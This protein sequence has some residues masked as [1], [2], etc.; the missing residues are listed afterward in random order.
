MMCMQVVDEDLCR[1]S[2]FN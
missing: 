2:E 1:G